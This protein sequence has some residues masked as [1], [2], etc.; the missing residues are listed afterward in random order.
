M[1]PT[2]VAKGSK[3]VLITGSPGGRTII[4]TVL[5]V[6]SGALDF[7]L[8]ARAAVDAPRIH[9]AWFPDRVRV[10]PELVARYPM[11]E[12]ELQALGHQLAKPDR[13]GD[14]HTISID[15]ATGE[16]T[17]AADTRIHGA[18]AGF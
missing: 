14:A 12:S 5:C 17:A 4:N 7:Q 16:I 10:E 18:A 1:C 11:L 6:V 8:D 15:L 13:Q 3:P 2:I 9:H